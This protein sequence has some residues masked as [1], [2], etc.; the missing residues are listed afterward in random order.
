[1]PSLVYTRGMTDTE[2]LIAIQKILDDKPVI[3]PL[4]QSMEDRL[5]GLAMDWLESDQHAVYGQTILDVL[6]GH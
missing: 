2:K 5:R 1:M 3:Q 4:A 6:D